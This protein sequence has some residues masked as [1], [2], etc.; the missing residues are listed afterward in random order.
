MIIDITY[1]SSVA[2][3]PAGYKLAVQAA[4][5]FFEKTFSTPI[6]V[7]ITVGWGEV[8]GQAL[9]PD[10][11]GA[12]LTTFVGPV[13]ARPGS[14][15]DAL[16]DQVGLPSPAIAEAA[17]NLE[18]TAP[19]GITAAALPYAEARALLPGLFPADPS[20]PDG[21]VG[22]N[23][24][25]PFT[26]SASDRAVAGEYDAIGVLEHEISEVLGR[27]ALEGAY[28]PGG[29]AANSSPVYTA[30]DFLRWSAPGVHTYTAGG[31]YFSLNG[32]QLLLPFNNPS[33]GGDAGDWSTAAPADS[34]D[35][36]AQPGV[37]LAVSAVDLRV[38]EMLGYKVSDV[39]PTPSGIPTTPLTEMTNY[40]VAA[41]QTLNFNGPYVLILE[42]NA[43]VTNNGT[44]VDSGTRS[45]VDVVGIADQYA[46]NAP[47]TTFTNAA[48]AV[49]SVTATAIAGDAAGAF[50]ATAV[51]NSGLIQVVSDQADAWGV[52]GNSF[53]NTSTGALTVQA[54]NDA[55]GV[56]YPNN[57]NAFSNAGKIEVTG[58]SATGVE[59][60]AS[61]NNSGTIEATGVGQGATSAAVYY[62]ATGSET[63]TNSGLIQ[64]GYAFQV[65]PNESGLFPTI[66][67]ANSGTIQGIVS[68]PESIGQIDNTGSI[69]GPIHFGDGNSVYNGVGGT[70]SGGIFLGYGTN[71]V[72]LGNDGEA[73]VGGGDADTIT[74]GSGNDFIEIDLG[75]NTINGGGGSNTLSFADAPLAVTV[76]M[77]TGTA[78]AD[79]LDSFQNIQEVI[80]GNYGNTM[81]AGSS[82]VTF[83]AGAGYD[84]LMGGAGNDTL[85][86]GA[87]G[88]TMTGGGGNNT[89]IYSTGDHQLTVTDFGANGDQ[90]VLQIYGYTAAQSIVQQGANTLVTLS[91]NDSILLENV[92]ASSLTPGEIVYKANPYQA[93]PVPVSP[94]IFGTTTINMD[95]NLTVLAGEV[96]DEA[97][98]NVGI[99][100]NANFS[101]T[102]N[103]LINFGEL[104]V[105]STTGNVSGMV[106]NETGG[107]DANITNEA[108]A[109]F[110]VID[111]DPAGTVTG[112]NF[113]IDSF[114]NS[115]SFTVAGQG[116]ALGINDYNDN[117]PITNAATGLFSVSSATGTATGLYLYNGDGAEGGQSVTN[118][119]TFHVSGAAAAYGVA[120]YDEDGQFAG[121]RFINNGTIVVSG[122]S[123]A[124]E[125]Y[126]LYIAADS[127]ITNTG[128]ITAGIAIDG[129]GYPVGQGEPTFA[130]TNSG[131]ING[132]IDIDAANT[133][134]VNTG[135]VNGSITLGDGDSSYNGTGG[136]LAGVLSL[137]YGRNT[138]ILGNDGESV[139]GGGGWDD[140]TGGAGNDFI[141]IG[142]GYNIVNGGA[143]I[144]T[145]SFAD[146]DEAVTVNLGTGIA[147]G[148][149][150]TKISNIQIVIGSSFNDTL[151]AGVSG[152]TLIAGSGYD[153]LTGGAGN[154]TLVAGTGGDRTTGG[155]GD[156]TFIYSV[157]DRDLTITD[158]GIT[159]TDDVL[160]IYGY[161]SAISVK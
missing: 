112:I 157:G 88:D 132:A 36:F 156:N 118:D 80:G 67:I 1:D 45:Q 121:M 19:V 105:S 129:I 83:V 21:Y 131:I 66:T 68:L 84:T 149:G 115:G 44:I 119:G 72:T 58:L 92:T 8:D 3:A 79:G 20:I 117:V 124:T 141:E 139:I 126:G 100:D 76:N 64:G 33:D 133:T 95:Y 75:N 81:I 42:D 25:A 12:S 106:S 47:N 43:A 22:L 146:S 61:F 34:F 142:R 49:L 7:N 116:N 16:L 65:D 60:T 114:M 40:S 134:I 77:S 6:T 159:G 104:L 160:E 120:T 48:N 38:M 125:T 155:G 135:A 23:S 52:W 63:F 111:I 93:P 2:N 54:L 102:L 98:Q 5:T 158:F 101:G 27:D 90:D 122:T 153:T 130:I 136:T 86:A 82:A 13:G 107:Q 154:D 109:T 151:I 35:A 9:G 32:Q 15:G 108:G 87:G 14:L 11:L 50:G 85:I 94:P 143:G 73:V 62:F 53:T 127:T 148:A 71:I 4:V 145:L 152:A 110:S 91:A 57:G 39:A 78:I 161:S 31:G 59:V 147:T 30:L 138:V 97:N 113:D 137:G 51:T 55:I 96:I 41:G 89:F 10:E 28:P 70:Q 56:E 140:I 144:N 128:T 29:N 37:E 24:S 18:A 103:N 26:F 74:G 46:P 99:S 17:E 69:T 123:N 150:T